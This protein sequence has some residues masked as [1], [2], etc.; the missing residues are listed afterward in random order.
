MITQD[1][2][3]IS[4]THPD[5]DAW[6]PSPRID[7]LRGS[8]ELSTDKDDEEAVEYIAARSK[9]VYDE[10]DGYPT[11]T[12]FGFFGCAHKENETICP[13]YKESKLLDLLNDKKGFNAG[14]KISKDCKLPCHYHT[15]G[16]IFREDYCK[17]SGD[18]QA[19]CYVAK[20]NPYLAVKLVQQLSG[21]S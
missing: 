6:R 21:C 17:Y 13:H 4:S 16:D 15:N 1:G 5:P 20:W 10:A 12:D 9:K 14:I 11:L 8:I 18:F 3:I 19:M 2:I 7:I